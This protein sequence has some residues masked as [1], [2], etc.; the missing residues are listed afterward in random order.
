MRIGRKSLR[1]KRLR[2]LLSFT[3]LFFLSFWMKLA[4][5]VQ[6]QVDALA[7]D[8]PAQWLLIGDLRELRSVME[9]DGVSSCRRRDALLKDSGLGKS[10]AG[11]GRRQVSG[12]FDVS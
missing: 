2:P 10:A 8:A 3:L 12:R 4:D 6:L 11:V 7:G 5:V 9:D 1:W